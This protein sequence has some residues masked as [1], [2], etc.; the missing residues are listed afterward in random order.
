[1]SYILKYIRGERSVA[2]MVFE[3]IVHHIETNDLFILV[4]RSIE[5]FHMDYVGGLFSP[6]R[7]CN[8]DYLFV[9]SGRLRYDD[10]RNRIYTVHICPSHRKIEGIMSEVEDKDDNHPQMT[11]EE[12]TGY[13]RVNYGDYFIIKGASLLTSEQV[14]AL[15]ASGNI[16]A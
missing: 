5:R 14:I 3:N 16:I 8:K 6:D 7:T 10:A 2:D 4:D 12:M 1:M 9:W 13:L 15:V 11:A